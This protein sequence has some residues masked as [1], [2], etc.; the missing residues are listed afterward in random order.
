[1][2]KLGTAGACGGFLAGAAAGAKLASATMWWSVPMY[3]FAVAAS[4]LLGGVIGAVGGGHLGDAIDEKLDEPKQRSE[5]GTRPYQIGFGRAYPRREE[6]SFT[7]LVDEL[8]DH[9]DT[10]RSKVVVKHEDEE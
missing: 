6:I 1:M 10:V 8:H 5:Y 2:K 9:I 7:K 4:A 3:P